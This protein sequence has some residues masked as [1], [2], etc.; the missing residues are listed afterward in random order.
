MGENILVAIEALRC[1]LIQISKWAV[2]N[3]FWS[4]KK[5]ICSL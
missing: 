1:D 4:N 3:W 2:G 5:S